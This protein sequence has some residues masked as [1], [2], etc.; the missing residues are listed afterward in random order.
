MLTVYAAEERR[1]MTKKARAT[2]SIYS[3]ISRNAD[4]QFQLRRRRVNDFLLSKDRFAGL[5]EKGYEAKMS[6]HMKNEDAIQGDRRQCNAIR[7]DGR[8]CT[9]PVVLVSGFCFAHDPSRK[10]DAAAGRRAGGRGRSNAARQ[11]RRLAPR[12]SARCD[13]LEQILQEL[14]RGE[15]DPRD[16][17]A[18]ASIV[19]TLVQLESSAGVEER[20]RALESLLLGTQEVE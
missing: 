17:T 6:V 13:F 2:N 4:G 15:L 9:C 20:L 11:Q 14:H 5:A 7:R 3:L 8:R 10:A 12:V 19:R 16:A 18:M 1:G